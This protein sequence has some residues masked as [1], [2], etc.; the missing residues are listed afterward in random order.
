[1]L[2]VYRKKVLSRRTFTSSSFFNFSRWCESVEFGM[3]SADWI[4]PTTRPSGCADNSN[5][6]IRSRGSVPMAESMSA[7]FATF[8]AVFLLEALAWFDTCRNMVTCQPIL[9]F[10]PESP[11]TRRQL[12]LYIGDYTSNPDLFSCG[13]HVVSALRKTWI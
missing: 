6:M 9:E 13:N 10:E 4:S 3:S 8:S 7:Y 12:L 1:V 11:A 5:C 2:A